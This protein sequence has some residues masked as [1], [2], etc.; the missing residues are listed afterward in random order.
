MKID[1]YKHKEKYESWKEKIDEVGCIEGISRKNSD[2]ILRYIF[3]M[4][5]G[6]NISSKSAKGS[7]SYI[8]LNN[9][10]QRMIFL[11]KRFEDHYNTED[12]T[13]LSEDE[14]IHFFA[15]MRNGEI[16]RIDG[17]KYESVVDFVKI[18][19]A[20]WHWHVKVSRKNKI[21]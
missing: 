17:G 18:F 9:L 13:S 8:R 7:R 10:K 16:K 14:I 3:D 15:K 5:V 20:F 11:T 21:G 2:L 19:K 1:P 4:E 12:I 6:I